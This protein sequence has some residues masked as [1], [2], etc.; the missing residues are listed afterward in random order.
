VY[1]PVALGGH[2]DF[3][4]CYSAGV[5]VRSGRGHQ[6]YDYE[7]QKNIQDTLISPS[8]D[9]L[10]YVH[11]PYEALLYAP[12]TAFSYRNAFFCFL[13]FNLFC[14]FACYHTLQGKLGRMHA[15]WRWFP[16]LFLI[17]FTP[18]VAALVQGQDSLITLLLLAIALVRLEAGDDTLA[19]F[20]VGLVMF[21]FQLVF[22][23]VGLFFLWRRWRFV[24][25]AGSSIFLT[26]LVSALVVGLH[27]LVEYAR[28]LHNISTTFIAGGRVL[29]VM[30]V[31]RM[32]NL[33]GLIL[34]IP[35]LRSGLATGLV[36]ILS[37]IFFGLA[38]WSGRKAAIQWQFAIAVAATAV[39][40]YHVLSHDLSILMVPM[41]VLLDQRE[42]RGL[43]SI[44]ILWLAAPLSFFAW[45]KL[46]ALPVLGL[47][48]LLAWQ[49][50]RTSSDNTGTSKE[51]PAQSE[52]ALS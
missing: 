19:G 18:I 24:L 41:A 5:I 40:G 15:L 44:T 33:R 29:Y 50:W 14:L 31:S 13:G 45:E 32:P 46:V 8:S 48:L 20:F 22:P 28:S 34:A 10:P 51:T 17:G 36:L 16:F 49:C 38:A 47:F 25:G 26:L 12:L 3:R 21:K 35:H 30:P 27:G 6:L 11:L 2:A 37:V 43:W 1:L 52:V 23:I 42:P 39:I 9:V 4:N 7:L